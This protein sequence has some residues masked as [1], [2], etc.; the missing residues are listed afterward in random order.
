MSQTDLVIV[1]RFIRTALTF[2]TVAADFKWTWYQHP[3]G[4]ERYRQE[5]D[6]LHQ[7][8]AER[9]LHLAQ[10]N[11]GLYI[12]SGQYICS[13][14]HALPSAYIVTLRP[15]QN[16]APSMPFDTVKKLLAVE[17][18][19]VP[20]SE[21][22]ASFSPTPIASASIAQVHRATLPDGTP[23]AVKVQH[24]SLRKE[25][26]SDLLAHL[27]VLR[28]TEF[29]F[30]RFHLSWIHDEIAENL[31]QE[32][33][34]EHEGR[35]AEKGARKFAESGNSVVHVPRVYWQRSSRRVL[36]M[37]WCDGVKVNDKA[38]MQRMGIQPV[39]AC[40]A[41]IT[42][43]AEQCFLSGFVHC[44]PHPGNILIRPTPRS[45]SSSSAPPFQV[46]IIDWGLCRQMR[47]SVR[48]SYC[49]LWTALILRHDDEAK[50]AMRSLGL[51]T[52]A[53]DDS[54]ELIAMS[55]LMRPYRASSIGFANRI[56]S[57]DMAVLRNTMANKMDHWIDAFQQMPRE[58]LL[59]LRNQ[60]Y[61]RAMNYDMG[62]PV[63]RFRIMA[64]M[65][66][67]GQDWR[68]SAEDIHKDEEEHGSS[69]N[70]LAV[71]Q[72]AAEAAA[73]ERRRSRRQSSVSGWLYRAY[74]RVEFEWS[75]LYADALQWLGTLL[76]R[77][78]ANDNI[79][80]ELNKMA[81]QAGESGNT[82]F[83]G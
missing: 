70:A 52:A 5:T 10:A 20:F 49:R 66:L 21:L 74:D 81:K 37:E 33:D 22:F 32:L 18:P 31:T 6:A 48:L 42:A 12:K 26:A 2:V 62:Q 83:G 58:L 35:N 43:L 46:V 67:K 14:N 29:F 15:L 9:L 30:P 57:Q 59:V 34:F 50:A 45:S 80:R 63:N 16:E 7:R 47:E 82:L 78:W 53:D 69:W 73:E 65:A 77:F 72:T 56:T 38:G 19:S 55:I 76:F 64:R 41:T 54:W 28:A 79:K 68:N 24:Q 1:A 11:R 75:L 44:D 3:E 23:V 39:D 4:S 36:T 51:D 17:F 40:R 61:V 60:N 71:Q 27:M 8:T 25:F 13:M